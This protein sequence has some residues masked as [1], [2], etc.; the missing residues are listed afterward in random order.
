MDGFGRKQGG[1]GELLVKG[2]KKRLFFIFIL[3]WGQDIF[4]LGKGKGEGL[5]HVDRLPI[6][7]MGGG[8]GLCDRLP[9]WCLTRKF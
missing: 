6:L 1:A 3:F 8:E 7:S 9:Y 4:S 2:K 5:Y